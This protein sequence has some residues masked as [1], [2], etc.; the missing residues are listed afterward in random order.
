MKK[1]Y[2]SIILM[3]SMLL[4]SGCGG[5]D[6]DDSN[7]GQNTGGNN[8]GG[9]NNGGSTTATGDW[10][11]E[12][13]VNWIT[14]SAVTV[15]LPNQFLDQLILDTDG[16]VIDD[17]S[18]SS[19]SY[20]NTNG[21]LTFNNCK[22][23]FLDEDNVTLSGTVKYNYSGDVDSLTYQNLLLTFDDSSEATVNGEVNITFDTADT[24]VL[25]IDSFKVVSD[26]YHDN[27]YYSMTTELVDYTATWKFPND[28]EF[29]IEAD[30]TLNVTDSPY[31][32]FSVKFETT[33]PNSFN[34][35]S[36]N[37]YDGGLKVVDANDTTNYSTLEY[38]SDAATL[39]Y[40]SYAKNKLVI[41]R[42]LNWEEVYDF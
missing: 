40:Q 29:S 1:S 12:D 38:N 41:N 39:L 18:C 21:T 9:N 2:F 27:K 24:T 10:T 17:S 30:G 33:A 15:V 25:S 42:T 4:L 5:S 32:D 31:E 16:F 37:P 35:E 7:N 23:T 11:N 22:T 3:S 19:G 26:E 28:N 8:S 34:Y 20:T 14:H 36:S 13:A 6:S